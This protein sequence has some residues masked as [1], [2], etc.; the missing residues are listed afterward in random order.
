MGRDRVFQ[1]LLAL[2]LGM[3]VVAAA[4]IHAQVA[5]QAQA[6]AQTTMGRIVVPLTPLPAGTPLTPAMFRVRSIPAVDVP[7]NALTS[8]SQVAGAVAKTDLYPGEPLVTGMVYANAAQATL[9]DQLPQ[10]MR[11]IDVAVSATQGVGGQLQAGDRVDVLGNLPSQGLGQTATLLAQDVPVL[12]T[13]SSSSSTPVS[14]G[15][16][17]GNYNSVILEVTPRQEVAIDLAVTDGSITLALRGALDREDSPP[18][19]FTPATAVGG[20]IS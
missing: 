17:G 1:I 13:V 12:E 20:N 15:S 19:T 11:A 5:A 14:A 3:G 18:I 8:T 7:L 16:S 6:K 4:L 9:P 2:G 10:G